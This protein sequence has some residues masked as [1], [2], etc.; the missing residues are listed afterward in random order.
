MIHDNFPQLLHLILSDQLM[1]LCS[2]K[3]L[4]ALNEPLEL[5]LIILQAQFGHDDICG[6][7]DM[8]VELTCWELYLGSDIR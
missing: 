6:V 1:E 3:S 5:V 8:E 2:L 4:K 7:L